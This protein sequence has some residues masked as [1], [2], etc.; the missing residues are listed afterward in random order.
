MSRMETALKRF[1]QGEFLIV[2]DDVD[3]ENE[4]DLI[5]LAEAASAGIE[6]EKIRSVAASDVRTMIE[7]Y[8]K[9]KAKLDRHDERVPART[10]PQKFEQ[11]LLYSCQA[12]SEFPLNRMPPIHVP[13]LFHLVQRDQLD[14]L[15]QIHRLQM[16]HQQAITRPVDPQLR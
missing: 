14:R 5:L 10:P 4:A 9:F 3:R 7:V 8:S 13:P 11:V 15:Q 1:A 2:T 6:V 12:F 16:S